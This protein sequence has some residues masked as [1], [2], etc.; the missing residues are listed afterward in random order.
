MHKV[1]LISL[2]LLGLAACSEPFFYFS[3]GRLTGE[4]TPL[5]HMPAASGV[6]QIETLPTDPYS[7]NI[8]YVLLDG[9][10]YIDPAEDRQWY[11]N[12]LVDPTVR[13][14]FD[15][16]DQVH[17]MMTVP[18]SNLEILTQFDPTRIILRLEPIEDH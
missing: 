2:A 17:P 1:I 7:V 9:K 16:S 8:G 11:Q 12:I 14:R 10:V 4:E 15:G 5:V 13:I 18:E 3:G 6:L